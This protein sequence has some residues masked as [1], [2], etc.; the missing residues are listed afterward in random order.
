MKLGSKPRGAFTLLEIMVAITLLGMVIFAIYASWMAILK[1]KTVSETVT[2]QSQRTRIT[3]HTL[4]DA[5]VCACMFNGNPQYYSF[6]AGGSADYASLSFVARLPKS[7][8]RSG[9]F[10]DLDVRRLTFTVESSRDNGQQLVLRQNPLLMDTDT[11]EDNFPLVLAHH[12]EKFIVEFTDPKSGD[13]ITEWPTTN[14]LPRKVRVQL[15][16]HNGD[17]YSSQPSDVLVGTVAIAAQAVRVEW[18]MPLNAQSDVRPTNGVNPG[19]KTGPNNTIV[20]GASGGA[21]QG[22]AM[23]R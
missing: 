19:I 14:Q 3:M 13:W 18:Q 23:P 11:D 1:A 4:Q 22:G 7:F 15:A 5:L 8:P 2:A 12:V 9:K 10:G 16:L 6:I 21:F 17:S 20:P